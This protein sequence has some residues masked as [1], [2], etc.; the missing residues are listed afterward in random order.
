MKTLLS[1][2][3]VFGAFVAVLAISHRHE[4]VQ[5]PI[6]YE[7]MISNFYEDTAA[8]N[9]IAAI[10][11]NYRMYDTMFEA[12]ILLTAIIGMKQFLPAAQELKSE[13]EDESQS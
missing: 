8:H 6:L 7:Y 1:I 2:L 4:E 5:Q 10:L 9:A 3:F 12:L 11:L 13:K